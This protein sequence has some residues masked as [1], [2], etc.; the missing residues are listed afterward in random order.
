MISQL[1]KWIFQQVEAFIK[2]DAELVTEEE[3]QRRESICQG[4]PHMKMERKKLYLPELPTCDACTCIIPVK[5]SMK[6]HMRHKDMKNG[7]L[8]EDE[9][10]RFAKDKILNELNDYERVEIQCPKNKW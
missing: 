4:C 10:K 1:R 5:A 7:P 2:M 3:K 8:T 9:L 6:S